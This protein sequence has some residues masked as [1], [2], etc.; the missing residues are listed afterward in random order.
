[1]RPKTGEHD[2]VVEPRNNIP[3]ER[4]E[5]HAGHQEEQQEP[6]RPRLPKP[7]TPSPLEGIM[8]GMGYN[9][10]NTIYKPARKADVE[11]HIASNKKIKS[12]INYQLTDFTHGL[13]ET[14]SWYLKKLK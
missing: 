9:I 6:S 3:E 4:P 2:R 13:E 8:K 12:L 7:T 1:M 14:I 5:N 10:N 11:C